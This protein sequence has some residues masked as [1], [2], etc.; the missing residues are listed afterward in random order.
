MSSLVG[1]WK[2]VREGS[3]I[4]P[5]LENLPGAP[6]I[7]KLL[8]ESSAEFY[9]IEKKRIIDIEEINLCYVVKNVS[10]N[11]SV[12]IGTLNF[13][14]VNGQ[15]V[16][17]SVVQNIDDNFREFSLTRLGPACGQNSRETYRL[18]P[19]NERIKLQI[20]FTASDGTRLNLIKYLT[21]F[22]PTPMSNEVV[23]KSSVKSQGWRLFEFWPSTMLTGTN[24]VIVKALKV[25]TPAPSANETG[26]VVEAV[27]TKPA[28]GDD[29]GSLDLSEVTRQVGSGQL[30]GGE[31]EEVVEFIVKV[32]S[33]A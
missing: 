29:G 1:K 31:G 25:K 3:D 10:V 13:E 30:S 24:V 14:Q 17:L 28:G 23:L 27:W 16:I 7:L 26:K 6:L 32:R 22:E 9:K 19:N 12:Q 18:E 11:K 33:G 8:G 4:M 5:G 21:R 15:E 2:L 20:D